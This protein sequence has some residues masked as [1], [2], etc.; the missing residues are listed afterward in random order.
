MTRGHRD[1]LNLRCTTL[2]FATPCRFIPALS[3]MPGTHD[4]IKR[5]RLAVRFNDLLCMVLL[6]LLWDKNIEG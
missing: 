2:S 1:W 3:A 5:R 6:F 4:R